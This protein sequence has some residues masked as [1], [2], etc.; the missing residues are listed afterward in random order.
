MMMKMKT[1][2]GALL[3]IALVSSS[4]GNSLACTVLAIRDANGNVYQARSNEFVGQQPDA[5]SYYPPGTRIESVTPDG[6]QG[7]S[8]NTKYAIF[9]A[10]LKGM[11]PNAK[12]ETIHEAVNDQ[13]MSLTTNAFM[14]NTSPAITQPAEK[15]LSVVDFGTWALG[16]FQN[17]EQVKQALKN[18]EVDLWLPKI[19]S[20][21]DLVTPLHFAMY[22]KK[23]GSIVIE[24][25]Y[26]IHVYDNPSYVMTNDPSLP[27]HLQNLNDYADL[28]NIDKNKQQF[29]GF[30]ARAGSGGIALR[31]LP[32][33]QLSSGRF[34]KAAFYSNFARKAKTPEQA[35]FTLG[36]VMNN[37]DRPLDISVDEPVKGTF[38]TAF[39]TTA[40]VGSESTYFTVLNDLSQGHFYIRTINSLN[41]S[42]F[43][44]KKL[45]GLKEIT[46]VKFQTINAYTDLNATVLFLK[47]S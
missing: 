15:V 18:K 45:S 33:N 17:V 19:A 26:G 10:T 4:V 23:G 42:K 41:F 30:V 32:S 39:S 1:L 6:K 12:Q 2:S 7:K 14:G 5:L 11:T 3:A 47:K 44:I 9:G 43:D 8:F 25:D 38:S 13:G 40:G 36:H 29:N 22:D 37:F 35:I 16:S 27:W 24:F 21:G 46:V 20:M 34:V 31:G 28:T